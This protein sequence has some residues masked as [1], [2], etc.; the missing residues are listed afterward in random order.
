MSPTH[1]P[2]HLAD[3]IAAARSARA[4]AY[5]PYSS[6]QV[7][8]VLVATDGRIFAGCNVENVSYGGTICAERNALGAAVLAGAR[9]F[10]AVVVV[11]DAPRPVFPCGICRQMLAEFGTDVRVYAVHGEGPPVEA[12]LAALLPHAFESGDI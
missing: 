12:S 10:Q 9:A 4:Q 8:S 2:E 6:F 1:S 3:W 7:G 11:T 5:A